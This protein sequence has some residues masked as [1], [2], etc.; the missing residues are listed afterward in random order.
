[1]VS[2]RLMM[3]LSSVMCGSGF[4]CCGSILWRNYAGHGGIELGHRVSINSHRLADPIGG[5]TRTIIVAG[6]H[7]HIILHDGVSISNSTLFSAQR[8]EIGEDTCIGGGCKI[9]DTDFHS[10]DAKKRLDNNRDVPTR[11]VVIGKRVFI[12][13]HTLILKGVTIGDEAVIG[14]GSIVTRDVPVGEIWAGN[15]AR[16]IRKIE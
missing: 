7:G 12:G 9:Y 8:I 13:G 6:S 14:A 16:F 3:A 10:V 1:M 5:D 2:N 11:P 15:P 4:S